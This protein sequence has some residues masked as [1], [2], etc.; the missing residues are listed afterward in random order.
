MGVI[1]APISRKSRLGGA[2]AGRPR[3]L[4]NEAMTDW[5][6]W[7]RH[8]DDPASS[9]SKRLAVVQD[10]FAA[11]LRAIG[12]GDR[13]ILSLCAGDGRDLLPVLSASDR[14]HETTAVLVERE[15]VLAGAARQRA[16]QLALTSVVVRCGDAGDPATFSDVTPVDLL[17]VCGVF[18][19]IETDDLAG[20]VAALPGLLQ[21]GG[22]V[23]WTRGGGAP[24]LRPHV[25][26]LFADAGFD[27]SG[28]EGAPASYGV[29]HARLASE[30]RRDR[31]PTQGR[32]FTFVK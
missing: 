16:T 2:Q 10:F 12:P 31:H 17:L 6:D 25:R 7:H 4:Q 32:L 8:Y 15:P 26:H 24:D 20:T 3:L 28:Y 9:L 29:G 19:N 13:R 21:T 30:C 11:G 1:F 5:L 27:E 22:Q 23:I 14:R 18:G